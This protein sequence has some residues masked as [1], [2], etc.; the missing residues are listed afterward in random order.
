ML[1]KKVAVSIVKNK[2][3]LIFILILALMPISPVFAESKEEANKEEIK[4]AIYHPLEPAFVVN[5]RTQ[6]KRQRF[7]QVTIQLMTRDSEVASTIELHDPAIRH[8]I[9]MLFSN[10]DVAF[11]QSAVGR[12]ELRQQALEKL[13]QLFSELTGKPGIEAVYITDY[14]IQ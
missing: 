8:T 3:K 1:N 5:L 6:S 14:V 11:V 10:Q 13:Q 7:L 9:L 12:E 4:K 2:T